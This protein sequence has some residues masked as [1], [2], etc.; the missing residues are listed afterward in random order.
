MST[1]EAVGAKMEET[2]A[3]LLQLWG[4]EDYDRRMKPIVAA[5]RKIGKGTNRPPFQVAI[6]EAKRAGD[7]GKEGVVW[8]M[9][10]AACEIAEAKDE[11]RPH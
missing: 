4:R 8:Q 11:R 6:A 9:T 2:R 3:Y 7:E 1:P 5:I 10:A